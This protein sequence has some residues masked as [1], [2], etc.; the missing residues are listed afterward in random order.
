M[1][2]IPTANQ[3]S[4][5]SHF[6][7]KSE[8]IFSTFRVSK[9]RSA[10]KMKIPCDAAEFFFI[11]MQNRFQRLEVPSLFTPPEIYCVAPSLAVGALNALATYQE[12]EI[13]WTNIWCRSSPPIAETLLCRSTCWNTHAAVGVK[14]LFFSPNCWENASRESCVAA[15]S[16]LRRVVVA[17]PPPPPHE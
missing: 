8:R 11:C 15:V 5:E 9:D 16:V 4:G 10:T 14:T 6:D 1:L 2:I 17:P 3:I 12:M 13:I 7:A